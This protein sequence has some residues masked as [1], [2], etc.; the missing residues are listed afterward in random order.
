MPLPVLPYLTKTVRPSPPE[1]I[2]EIHLLSL[3]DEFAQ[4]LTTEEFLTQV[5]V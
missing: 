3:Q 5:Q 1:T 2:H 4:I